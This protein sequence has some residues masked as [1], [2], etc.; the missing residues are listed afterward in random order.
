M[1]IYQVIIQIIATRSHRE[2]AQVMQVLMRFD[3]LQLSQSNRPKQSTGDRSGPSCGAGSF[4]G[5][6]GRRSQ[7]AD[8]LVR[9]VKDGEVVQ[10]VKGPLD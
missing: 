9:W 3:A 8:A 1:D 5:Y 2:N 7:V 6:L 10:E 4:H